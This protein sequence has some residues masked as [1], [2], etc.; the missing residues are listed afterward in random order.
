LKRKIAVLL[1]LCFS[2][3]LIIGCGGS[4]N[5]DGQSAVDDSW[6]K[7][8]EQGYF[9]VGLDDAFP[10][11]GFREEGTNDIVGFDIDLAKEAASRMGVDVKFKPVVWDTVIETLNIGDI[12]AIW[13]GCTITQP[14]LEQINFTKPYV[15]DHQIIVVQKGSA[16]TSKADLAGKTIGLQAGSSAKEAVQKDA[17][18]FESF[19]DLV[20]FTSNDEAL[21]DL[22]AG[23]MD[24]VVVDEVV[25]R[26]YIAKKPDTYTVLTEH[27]GEEEF[28]VG[29]R[30]SDEAF[31]AEL[32]KALD[33]M[34]A[35]GTAA[36]ISQKWFGEDITKK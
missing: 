7:I 4:N 34:K 23:R 24:A 36:E 2:A 11:M 8:Q 3:V 27:F 30:K 10:P 31:L 9:T 12:D 25:G 28:G 35:D 15:A 14:R 32:N 17:A 29:V 19:G 5:N 26:Y 13:N 21:L 1:L 20:E 6:T 18:T 16:I 33:A 22:S